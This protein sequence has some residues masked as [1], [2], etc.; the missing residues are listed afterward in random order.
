M[1]MVEFDSLVAIGSGRVPMVEF[2]PLVAIGSVRTI[3]RT[4][5]HA[6]QV[7]LTK[8]HSSEPEGMVAKVWWGIHRGDGK[9]ECVK[10]HWAPMGWGT[11]QTPG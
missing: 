8:R 3:I 11:P 1:P 5:V 10:R 9:V 4:Y 2:D 6:F 7:K